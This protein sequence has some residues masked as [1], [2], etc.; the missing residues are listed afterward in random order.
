MISSGARSIYYNTKVGGGAN[1]SHKIP[2]CKAA[3]IKTPNIKMR[4][5][6]VYTAKQVG[7]KRIGIGRTCVHLDNDET[8]N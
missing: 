2:L 7:F 3:D 5:K 4:N 6:I 8:K 1:S